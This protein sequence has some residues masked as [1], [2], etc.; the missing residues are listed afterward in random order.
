MGACAPAVAWNGSSYLV[1]WENCTTNCDI[2]QAVQSAGSWGTPTPLTTTAGDEHNPDTDGTVVV[3]DAVAKVEKELGSFPLTITREGTTMEAKIP[4]A[5]ANLPLKAAAKMKFDAT[6]P[7][8]RCTRAPCA[9]TVAR[10]A[11]RGAHPR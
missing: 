5:I 8:Q 2:D 7:P 3:Y 6:K 1:V 9:S 11:D 10:S 4:A